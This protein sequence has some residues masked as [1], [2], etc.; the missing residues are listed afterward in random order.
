VS[1]PAARKPEIA[2]EAI[3]HDVECG[4][5]TADLPLWSELAA[6]AA[7]PVLE[8]GCGTGR[9]AL[10][11][12]REGIE[13]T[14]VDSSPALLEESGRRAAAE[15]LEVE[16]VLADARELSLERRFALVIGPMQ[17]VHLLGGTRGRA[18]LLRRAH[19]HL[20][21]GG[22][23]ALALLAERLD[24][25]LNGDPALPDVAEHGGWVYSSQPIEARR[26]GGGIEVRRLRQRVSPAGELVEDLDL[27]FLDDLDPGTLEAEAAALGFA[28]RERIEVPPT[29]DHVGSTVVVLEACG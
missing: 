8:L 28:P 1:A 4:G 14:A 11:L 23:L 17:L 24:P 16:L 6:A 18:A 9:V 7:G 2:E 27:V 26:A 15:G 29:P 25:A 13:V 12:A 10:A 20:A 5:Y 22:A 3:W 21:P 19:A